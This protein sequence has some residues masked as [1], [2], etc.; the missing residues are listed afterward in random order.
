[1]A[2]HDLLIINLFWG[3]FNLLPIYPLDGGQLA[4]VFLTMQNRREGPP[5]PTSSGSSRP[6]W[7]SPSTS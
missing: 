3:L 4:N 1:M 5:G 2:Y 7:R 6:G